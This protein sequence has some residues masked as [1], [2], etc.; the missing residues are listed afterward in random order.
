M[1]IGNRNFPYPVLNKNEALSD[2]I[3]ESA[4]KMDFD[5]DENDTPIEQKD[6]KSVV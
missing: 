1:H 3:P 4:F 5:V 6:R 2:Y